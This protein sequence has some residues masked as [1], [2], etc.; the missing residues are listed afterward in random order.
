MKPPRVVGLVLC[1]SIGLDPVKVEYNLAGVFHSLYF[2]RW[3]T[4]P[5]PFFIYAALHGGSG[6]GTLELLV[7]RLETE[8]RVYR[9]KR[10]YAI[11]APDLVV[12]LEIPV[13]GCSFPAA[14]RYGLSL[15]VD[16]KEIAFR[17][18]DVRQQRGKR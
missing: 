18:L 15:R 3:P 4:P 9:Y 5:Q 6:D 12:H 1:K 16:E 8:E 11:P 14:G 7:S 2:R 10:P 13:R 17:I